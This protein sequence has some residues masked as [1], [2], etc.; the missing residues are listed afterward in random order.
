MPSRIEC[1]WLEPT[2]NAEVSLRRY[3][4][5][6]TSK[7]P[8]VR[9]SYPGG[10]SSVW[11]YHDAQVKTEVRVRGV[12]DSGHYPTEEELK[13]P[14][15]PMTCACGYVFSKN[16]NWQVNIH[17][18][19]MRCDNHDLHTLFNAPVGAMWDAPWFK[20]HDGKHA[21]PDGLYLV[22]RTPAGD[23]LVDGPSSNGNSAGWQ[24]TGKPPY[25]SV[26]PSIG[27]GAPMRMHGWLRNGVLE[28]DTP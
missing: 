25:I 15:W 28:I 13:D 10:D 20:G 1:F 8:T 2:T 4:D 5:S 26:T 19:Y 3:I 6:P 9:Q 11:G 17:T 12:H 7:C 27:F 18:L 23:W 21:K 14:R 24:R 22:V 16:D